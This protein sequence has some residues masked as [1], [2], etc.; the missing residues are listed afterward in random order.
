MA[1]KS[2]KDATHQVT[3]NISDKKL[4]ERLFELDTVDFDFFY[5]KMAVDFKNSKESQSFSTTVKMRVDSAFS[6][7]IKYL[8]FVG[9]TYLIDKDSLNFTNKQKKCYFTEDLSYISALLGTELE[10]DFFQDLILGKPIKLD[11]KTKYKQI[12]DRN[13]EYYILSSH[14]RHQF[15][16][17]EK[18]NI[19][20]EKD[21]NIYMQYYFSPDSLDLIKMHIEIPSDT[22]T[23][24]INYL[25]SEI[26][27]GHFVPEKTTMTIVHPKDSI[28]LELDY[29]KTK[30]NQPKTINFSVPSSYVDC[31]Q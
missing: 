4:R 5:T 26:I 12:R 18:D 22:V 28:N 7:T 31:N 10:Y 25:E 17:I 15:Q 9:G 2:K 14:S 20:V 11:K 21:N 13:K 29:S 24:D 16:R 19:N 23:I 1:C 8:Q 30:I 27:E 3:K 6:G